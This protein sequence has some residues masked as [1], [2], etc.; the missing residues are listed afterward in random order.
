MRD[1]RK[2][3]VSPVAIG[4]FITPEDIADGSGACRHEVH[5]RVPGVWGTA[6]YRW[7]GEEWPRAAG[8]PIDPSGR[9]RVPGFPLIRLPP[10]TLAGC[11]G[12]PAPSAITGG[13]RKPHA[14]GDRPCHGLSSSAARERG[15][16]RGGGRAGK[17]QLTQP[18]RDARA[19]AGLREPVREH[20][21]RV[22]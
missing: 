13:L 16:R 15:R 8:F 20:L 17:G 7:D 12:S 6:A 10:M 21:R 18:G 4:A 1:G 9:Q 5:D 19:V 3:A 22:L 14:P 11:G 2:P